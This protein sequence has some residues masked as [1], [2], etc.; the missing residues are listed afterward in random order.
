M[1]TL[2]AF[3]LLLFS[4]HSLK[5]DLPYMPI[6]I[7]M[8]PLQTEVFEG[9]KLTFKVWL[10]NTDKHTT[11]PV[12][13]PHN[14]N[15]GKKLFYFKVIDNANNYYRIV[16]EESREI[17]IP[18][19]STQPLLQFPK[20][21]Q[22]APQDSISFTVT[23][24]SATDPLKTE[25]NHYFNAPLTAGKYKFQ[26][27]YAP[28]ETVIGDS[29]YNFI[30][31]TNASKASN[32]LNFWIG[33]N[34]TYPVDIEIKRTN[35]KKIT[36]EGTTYKVTKI[37]ENHSSVYYIQDSVMAITTFFYPNGD[38]KYEFTSNY[39]NGDPGSMDYSIIYFKDGDIKDFY[40]YNKNHCPST[41]FRRTFYDNKQLK[42]S[43]DIGAHKT[44]IEKGFSDK[45]IMINKHLYSA[46]RKLRTDYKYSPKNSNLKST[47]EFKN[48][49]ELIEIR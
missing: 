28:D 14:Q 16:A 32:K 8:Q 12:L 45:G 34:P 40:K 36:I 49:C 39:R 6:R 23:W 11:Y 25:N 3:L 13:L 33:G 29:L 1:K 37:E 46:D 21:V 48:P 2:C 7:W 17:I 31:S 42:F 47:E 30:F 10:K 5:A 27:F 18:G 19:T 15:T 43:A 4:Y 38:K 26:G 35:K 22:L 9:E 41:I 24:N 44:F 20:Q